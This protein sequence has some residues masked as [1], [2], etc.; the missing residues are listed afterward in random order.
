MKEL[1]WLQIVV[2]RGDERYYPSGTLILTRFMSS[3]EVSTGLEEGK[4]K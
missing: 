4:V 2:E 3:T 1:G